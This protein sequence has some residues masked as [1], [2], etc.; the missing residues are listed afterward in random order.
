[1]S[2]VV[3]GVLHVCVGNVVDRRLHVCVS[4]VDG[5]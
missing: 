4:V 2:D 3:D 1:M 5:E